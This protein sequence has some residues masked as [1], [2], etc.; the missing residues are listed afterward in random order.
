MSSGDQ[1]G[2]QAL[3]SG[4]KFFRP[5]ELYRFKLQVFQI[6]PIVTVYRID[7]VIGQSIIDS[8]KALW[9]I[10]F[11]LDS[12]SKLPDVINVWFPRFVINGYDRIGNPSSLELK[13]DNLVITTTTLSPIF[14]TRLACSNRSSDQWKIDP[15]RNFLRV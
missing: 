5:G 2:I 3:L 15:A 13:F 1:Y 10:P 8:W 9:S 14:D 6:E 11:V 4:N 12:Y 7:L